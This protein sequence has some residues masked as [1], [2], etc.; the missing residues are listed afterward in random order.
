M[1]LIKLQSVFRKMR[2]LKFVRCNV[3]ELTVYC[4]LMLLCLLSATWTP[5]VEPNPYLPWS[6]RLL[7]KSRVYLGEYVQWSRCE[8]D[9]FCWNLKRLEVVSFLDP[10]SPSSPSLILFM[11]IIALMTIF[12]LFSISIWAILADTDFGS[13]PED[14]ERFYRFVDSALFAVLVIGCAAHLIMTAVIFL[15]S[16]VIFDQRFIATLAIQ[17]SGFVGCL[18][19]ACTLGVMFPV[20]VPVESLAHTPENKSTKDV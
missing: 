16:L 10:Y 8:A 18:A 3:V 6:P 15:P 11:T 13:D 1:L 4:P 19:M 5:L 17:L 12:Y 14:E 2:K 9:D 7:I 20:A